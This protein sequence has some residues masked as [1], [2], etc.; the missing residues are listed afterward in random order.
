MA[1]RRAYLRRH[2]NRQPGYCERLHRR[3]HAARAS[4]PG[5]WGSSD[6]LRPRLHPGPGVGRSA[7]EDRRRGA[8]RRRAVLRRGGALAGATSCGSSSESPSRCL[9]TK[10]ASEPTRSLAPLNVAAMR[11]AFDLPGV[12]VAIAV[13]FL[14]VAEL[15]EPG[16]DLHVLLRRSVRHRRARHRVRAGVHRRG[17]GAACKGAWCVRSRS[18]STRSGLVRAGAAIQAVAFAGLVYAG[19]LGSHVLLFASGAVL[20]LGNGLTQPS[21]SALHLQ[22]RPRRPSGRHPRHQPDVREPRAHLRP[23]CGG[24]ALLEPRPPG[25]V[26]GRL[27][28][29][30][31]RARPGDGAAQAR[32]RSASVTPCPASSV[33][34]CSTGTSP[35]SPAAAAASA[36]PSRTRSCEL[37]AQ[38]AIAGAKPGQARRPRR[39]PLGAARRQ[40]PRRDVRHPRARAG[41]PL[42]RRRARGARR[43]RRSS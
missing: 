1:L 14:V 7:R 12:G 21:T 4:A 5:A 36:S 3:R 19:T 13:N 10:R 38:V 30:G 11:E 22:A 32:R 40:R 15:H 18:G 9:P 33:P 42:R 34:A 2:R 41:R 35:S 31:R 26:R 24:M 23:R 37:G 39:T 20:A 17:G 25:A 29:Y 8:A 27:G 28:G 6:G 16:P 43:D